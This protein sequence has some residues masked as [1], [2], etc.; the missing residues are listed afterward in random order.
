MKRTFDLVISSLG[1]V[2]LSPLFLLIAF[3]ILLESP[4][5]VFFRQE[6][7]GKGGI[8]FRIFKFRSM[9]LNG[10]E[11][12]PQI[13][14]A[15]DRRVTRVG[16]FLRRAKLDEL[17]QLINV[18]KGE[19]SLVGPRPEVPAYVALYNERQRKVLFVQPGITD[20]AS[21]RYAHEESL[22]AASGD[23][24][25]LYVNDIM[26]R[27]LELNLDYIENMSLAKDLK[28]IFH[29]LM[30]IFRNPRASDCG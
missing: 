26:P 1:L 29:T 18:W 28:I 14:V 2:V 20:P 13:T 19:M 15:G 11:E 12:G 3:A 7:V 22:L 24:L 25:L 5:P 10:L 16:R 30:R 27:K 17:P 9:T 21:V 23:P 6:R 8:P 4:G